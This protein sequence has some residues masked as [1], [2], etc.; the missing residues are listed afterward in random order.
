MAEYW[1][2]LRTKF[3]LTVGGRIAFTL[4][5]ALAIAAGATG[6]G[7]A[8]YNVE[9]GHDRDQVLGLQVAFS[10]VVAGI[11]AAVLLGI[12]AG[13]DSLFRTVRA[14]FANFS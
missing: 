6:T 10:W 1:S 11:C 7:F 5:L 3:H 8:F 14:R 12:V 4:F 13:I 9:W 2:W